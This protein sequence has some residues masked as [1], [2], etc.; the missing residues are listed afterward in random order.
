MSNTNH[1]FM[2]TLEKKRTVQLL[3]HLIAWGIVYGI[4]FYYLAGNSN[5]D[6]ADYLLFTFNTLPYVLVFYI[7]YLFLIEK[8]IF[9]RRVQL[10]IALNLLIILLSIGWGFLLREVLSSFLPP[11]PDYPGPHPP[12]LFFFLRDSLLMSLTAGLSVAIK[13]TERW[14]K[15]ENERKE[16]ERVHAEAE[17]KH[18]K[19]Q[20]NPHFLFNT[21]NNIYALVAISPEKAQSTLLDLSK[22]MRYV[23]YE[24]NQDQVPLQKE[25]AFMKSYIDLMSL[26]LTDQVELTLN[27]DPKMPSVTI[28]PMLFISLIENAFKH[29]VASNKPSCIHISFS[30]QE[31]WLICAVE[32]SWHPKDSHDQSGS[33][34]GLDNLKKRL[35][36]LYPNRHSFVAQR[37]DNSYYSE[38]KILL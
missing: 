33:G 13:V 1:F 23:L 10:F 26:R 35:S 17:L 12:V 6:S 4:P 22:L 9:N 11:R 36:Y 5:A 31:G 27:I 7:N 34:I 37:R 16:W 14:Y 2:E 21:L 8:L 25:M 28:A 29:G 3:A 15:I 30:L 18:L 32:N 19:S 24:N 38:L 20:L